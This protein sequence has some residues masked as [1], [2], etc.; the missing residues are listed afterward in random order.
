MISDLNKAM[1]DLDSKM[2]L[3]KKPCR[4]TSDTGFF[5]SSML[6]PKALFSL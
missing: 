6:I 3:K 4:H 2:G 1:D 5:E